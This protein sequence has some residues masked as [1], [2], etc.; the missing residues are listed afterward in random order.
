MKSDL[1][2]RFQIPSSPTIVFLCTC[3]PGSRN[4]DKHL[5]SL[6]QIMA[7]SEAFRDLKYYTFGDKKLDRNLYNS[8]FTH[9][10]RCARR[11]GG[12]HSIRFMILLQENCTR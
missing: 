9:I 11:Y 1:M 7:A 4:G 8:F 6:V 12:S 10:K 5:K 3:L 2:T